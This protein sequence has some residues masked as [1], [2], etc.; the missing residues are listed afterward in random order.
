MSLNLVFQQMYKEFVEPNS[1][2]G[3]SMKRV[4]FIMTCT[5]I[6]FLLVQQYSFP[7][8]PTG[9]TRRTEFMVEETVSDLS[10]S[11]VLWKMV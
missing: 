7:L 5:G 6:S 10:I 8:L 11:P 9:E 3:N 4:P 2:H 1:I